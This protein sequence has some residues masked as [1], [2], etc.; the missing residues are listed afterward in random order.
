MGDWSPFYE[1]LHLENE[2]CGWWKW[3]QMWSGELRK[4]TRL[5]LRAII[6]LDLCFCSGLGTSSRLY[7][8]PTTRTLVGYK[9]NTVY[10]ALILCSYF[11]LSRQS[12]DKCAADKL[13]T[14]STHAEHKHLNR[15]TCFPWP[16]TK[17][18]LGVAHFLCFFCICLRRVCDAQVC[19]EGHR[20]RS[21][22][23]HGRPD[24]PTRRTPLTIMD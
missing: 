17:T 2:S 8:E 21:I 18:F 10:S 22:V 9:V 3:V 4:N 24:A 5:I 23:V 19:Q 7:G 12:W 20:S 14:A 11:C 16:W 13:T 1:T 6:L 15:T